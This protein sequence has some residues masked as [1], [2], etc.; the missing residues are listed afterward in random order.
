MSIDAW[1]HSV[2]QLLGKSVAGGLL[3]P[4]PVKLADLD[5]SNQYLVDQL[6]KAETSRGLIMVSPDYSEV[7]VSLYLENY[8]IIG[9]KPYHCFSAKSITFDS[10]ITDSLPERFWRI[11]DQHGLIIMLHSVKDLGMADSEIQWKLLDLC[12]R[13]PRA[14]LVLAHAARSF[15]SLH[16]QFV[17]SLRGL[18]NVYFDMSGICEVATIVTVLMNS[19]RKN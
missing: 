4:V 12:S 3:F 7:K 2:Q 5:K 1:R 15:H 8:K 13:Y 16:A 17:K 6:E 9:F 11:A 10:S 18:E 14:K 19:V